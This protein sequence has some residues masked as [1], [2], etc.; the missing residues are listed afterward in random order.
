[1]L[2]L[3]D[4][5]IGERGIEVVLLAG[6]RTPG[7]L[8]YADEFRAF[9]EAHPGFL[10]ASRIIFLLCAALC[11]AGVFASLARGKMHETADSLTS[12]D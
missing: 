8:I 12:A 9:A 1:M 2:P 7:E 10:A 6:A 4:R 5:L 3:I 11:L